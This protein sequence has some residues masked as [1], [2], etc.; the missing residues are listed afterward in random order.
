[1]E[2]L[3][4]CRVIDAEIPRYRVDPRALRCLDVCNRLLD[5]GQEGQDIAGITWIPFRDAIGKDKARGRVRG[6]TGLAAK[7]C[8]TIALAFEDGSDREIVGIDQFTV[9]QFLAVGEP[10]G[11]LA[12]VGMAAQGGVERFRDTCALGVTQRHGL[13]QEMLGLLPQGGHRLA[14]LQEFLFRLAHQFHK[15]VALPPALAAKAPHHF[16]QLLVECLGVTR[17]D[18]GAM[19][20]RL[21]DVCD[22]RQRFFWALYSV[23]ASVTRWLPCSQG[24]VSMTRCAGLTSPV[25]IAAAAWMAS[26]SSIRAASMRLRNSQRV[27]GK[28]KW[29]CA[30]LT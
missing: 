16:G 24:K 28:T 19:A 21:R 10:C 15:D 7:L 11:L 5:V 8:R 4:Q 25:S 1:M 13:V 23:V 30:G 12:D 27:S 18:C 6:D 17:E 20:A 2:R 22:E 14:K 29:A 9:R 26:S 3:T